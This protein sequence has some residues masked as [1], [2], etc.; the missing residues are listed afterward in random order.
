M[1]PP[2]APGQAE[3]SVGRH[4]FNLSVA[5][6]SAWASIVE[7]TLV[8]R[9]PHLEYGHLREGRGHHNGDSGHSRTAVHSPC[10]PPFLPFVFLSLFFSLF[11]PSM[12]D[13]ICF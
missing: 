13:L 10:V 9:S 6:V 2:P 5:G 11:I 1:I 8:W 12:G 3:Q 7:F 4:H